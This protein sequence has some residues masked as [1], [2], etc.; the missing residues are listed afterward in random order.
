MKEFGKKQRIIL[1]ILSVVIV[2]AII[3]YVYGTGKKD[4][5]EELIPY[6]ENYSSTEENNDIEE[7]EGGA[8]IVIYITG[9]VKNKGV[10]GLEEGSRITDAIDKAGGLTEEADIDTINLAY[11]LEDGMKIKIPTKKETEQNKSN[12]EITT[13]ESGIEE[14]KTNNNKKININT[15][16]QEELDSLDGIGASTANKIIEYRNENGKFKTIEDIKNVS[17]IGESKFKNIKD[18]IT[19]K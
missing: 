18:H 10:Y 5:S 8:E 1:I 4:Y 12:T 6:E 16:T 17:G 15:A 2:S 13:K 19:V 14:A 7:A 3:Y 11:L 9:A